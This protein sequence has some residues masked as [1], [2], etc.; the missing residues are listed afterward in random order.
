[1]EK[2]LELIKERLIKSLAGADFADV[3]VVG[4]GISGIQAALDLGTAERDDRHDQAKHR[5]RRHLFREN[6]RDIAQA[7]PFERDSAD[8]RRHHLRAG[9]APGADQQRN[10]ERQRGDLVDQML[11]VVR[12]ADRVR[13]TQE[14][15]K[16]PADPL[17]PEQ[18]RAGPHVRHI[19]RLRT[20]Q[21]LDVLR[22][23]ALEDIGHVVD[24][25]DPK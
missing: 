17:A 5:C 20:T 7:D 25:D 1:M 15:Q 22:R 21:P 3:M 10:E 23:L 18:E 19:E 4:G 16:Q 9:I 11:V 12:D 6:A 14:E 8:E 24:R 2:E 13:R